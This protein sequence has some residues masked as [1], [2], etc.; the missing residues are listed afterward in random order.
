MKQFSKQCKLIATKKIKS[1][2]NQLLVSLCASNF[3]PERIV[4]FLQK[5]AKPDTRK[6]V[7]VFPLGSFIFIRSLFTAQSCLA[8]DAIYKE[9]SQMVVLISYIQIVVVHNSNIQYFADKNVFIG[10]Q[11]N[12]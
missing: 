5:E 4:V 10:L 12:G 2:A 3:V 1:T 9:Y 8:L 11:P 7:F 6:V